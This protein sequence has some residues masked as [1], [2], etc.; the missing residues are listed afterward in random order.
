MVHLGGEALSHLGFVV[1]IPDLYGT[2]DSAGELR[3]ADWAIWRADLEQLVVWLSQSGATSVRLWG[4]R[5]GCL[6]A[7]ELAVN[8]KLP[9]RQLL[10]WQPVY[11][12]RQFVSQ[13]LRLRIAASILGDKPE[14]T[15]SLRI[16]LSAKGQLQVA[17][18]EV[19]EPLLNQIAEC[20]LSRS[21]PPATARVD[22]FE[23]SEG[24]QRQRNPAVEG[25]LNLWQNSGVKLST[26]R[27]AGTKFWTTQ[28]IS[29]APELVELTAAA[30]AN[31]LD[32][33]EAQSVAGLESHISRFEHASPG[34]EAGVTFS[35]LGSELIGVHHASEK[36][37]T[38]GV[39]IVVGG[40]QYR[41]G[42]HRL[43]VQL[44][45]RIANAGFPVLRFDYRGMGDSQ[46][47]FAGFEHIQDDIACAI[48]KF[49]ALEPQVSQI[50]LLGLCDAATAAS[51]YASSDDRV[52]GLVMLNP[53][54]YSDEGKARTLLKH[55]YLR[56]FFS[57]N[58]WRK[59]ASGKFM[60][61]QSVKDFIRNLGEATK[62]SRPDDSSSAC[63][64]EETQNLADAGNKPVGNAQLAARLE[65]ALAHYKG[66]LLLV[67][68][69]N[70][71]TADEF[72]E[73]LARFKQLRKFVSGPNVTN[74]EISNADHTFSATDLKLAL[75][76]KIIDWLR[77]I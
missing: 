29:Y 2:G 3:E 48:E 67:L 6:M 7:A 28:E 32:E 30:A 41:V 75:A 45:R 34:P 21:I 56:R 10:L 11:D 8:C 1:V 62:H 20:S 70:D 4:L 26:H 46:G 55:Y 14:T 73:S 13:F 71:L 27:V 51:F 57:K 54:V 24:D 43:F 74:H 53:W 31:T 12:G 37:N 60:P 19:S 58:L 64:G 23:I 69:G 66:K 17:G 9:V 65:E 42:S 33:S 47:E 59:I 77:S 52:T 25:V 72:R 44:A 39:I 49:A 63:T 68:S 38:K 61:R 50:V 18:Y 15:K 36:V 16:E 5:L 22:W 35:C 40:P 76:D